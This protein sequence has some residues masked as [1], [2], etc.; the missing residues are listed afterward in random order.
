MRTHGVAERPPL[1]GL[2]VPGMPAGAPGMEAPNPA[3]RQV[4]TIDA[5]GRTTA[6][7]EH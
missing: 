2:A 1:K 5:D 4:S 3:H 6:F 7:A